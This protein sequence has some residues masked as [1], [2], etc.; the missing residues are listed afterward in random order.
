M[1]IQGRCLPAK[2]LD[3]FLKCESA[4]IVASYMESV[5]EGGFSEYCVDI[6]INDSRIE[7][8]YH[9]V[10]MTSVSNNLWCKTQPSNWESDFC[11]NYPVHSL[12]TK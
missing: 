11:D 6:S 7:E 5:L 1:Y 3:I 8:L 4:S 10:I 2:I 12:L 9:R